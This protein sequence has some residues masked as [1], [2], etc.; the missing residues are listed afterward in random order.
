M[1]VRSSLTTQALVKISTGIAAIVVVSTVAT[2]LYLRSAL[3]AKTRQQLEEFVQTRVRQEQILFEKAASNLEIAKAE[4]LTQLKAAG[5]SDPQQ[6]FDQ[7]FVRY[8]DGVIRNR[9]DTPD[10][11]QAATLFLD[12]GVEVTAAVQRRVLVAYDLATN[13]G[14]AWIA[15]FPNFYILAPEN[16]SVGYWPTFDWAAEAG[17]D[18]YEPDEEYFKISTPEANPE[19]KTV[20][21]GTY[22]DSVSKDWL[23]SAVSPLYIDDR[24]IATLGQDVPLNDLVQRTVNETLPGTYNVI[25]QQ[26]GQPIVHPAAIEQL[27]Q[28]RE[29]LNLGGLED[30]KLSQMFEFIQNHREPPRFLSHHRPEDIVHQFNGE[31]LAVTKISGPDWYFVTVFP[32]SLLTKS[33]LRS[34]EFTFG[35]GIVMLLGILAVL[36][37]ILRYDVALPLQEFTE[38]TVQ[39]AQ[40]PTPSA[41]DESHPNELGRLAESF[42]RM[43]QQL[44]QTLLALQRSN[45]DLEQRVG[46]R[47]AELRQAME[48]AEN[49]SRAKSTFLANISHELRTPMTAIL[50]F[51]QLLCQESNLNPEQQQYATTIDRS[52]KQLLNLIDGILDIS[53]IETGRMEVSEQDFD[54]FRLL[55]DAIALLC[56]KAESKGLALSIERDRHVPQFVRTDDVKLRQ[57]LLNLL[58]NALKFTEKGHVILRVHAECLSETVVLNFEVEDSGPGIARTELDCLFQVFSQTETGRRS[59]QGTGLGLALCR[60]FVELMGG[61]IGVR[62]QLGVGSTFFFHVPAKQVH[63]GPD[64]LSQNELSNEYQDRERVEKEDGETIVLTLAQMPDRWL[65]TLQKACIVAKQSLM[66]EAIAQIPEEHAQVAEKLRDLVDT[67][68]FVRLRGF[69]DR[70]IAHRRSKY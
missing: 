24:H 26:D 18:F 43:A 3:D 50:G 12:D 22:Y 38:A 7:L 11:T 32:Q 23:V 66:Q 61:T 10:Y 36:W 42:N 57:I 49:A 64:R 17:P 59:H 31:Y 13:F 62:T 39:F 45:T 53:K 44:S 27:Q 9:P 5:N 30:R 41:I 60:T 8:A 29:Q 33:A 70:A 15:Q 47:T 25:F 51:A 2:Y 63:V 34:A 37:R 68:S 19:R 14:K 28:H 6:R 52:S 55:E 69:L 67:F 56:V 65:E 21:T 48:V 16:F 46:Q 35:L 4:M 20:W 54:L 40:G 58:G 1:Q